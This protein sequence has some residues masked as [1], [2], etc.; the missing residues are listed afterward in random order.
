MYLTDKSANPT[1]WIIPSSFIIPANGFSIIYCSGR[2]ELVGGNAH[3][4]FKITQTKGNEVLMLSDLTGAFQDSIAVMP[5]QNSHSRGREVDGAINWSVFT[6]GTPNSTIQGQ[7][8]NMN[9]L[10]FFLLL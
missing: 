9:Q 7:C 8:K 3:S 10:L 6:T 1:K 5:N 4:N 2:D